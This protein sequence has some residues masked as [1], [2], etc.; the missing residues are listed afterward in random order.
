MLKAIL[1][2]V[3][4]LGKSMDLYDKVPCHERVK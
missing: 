4:S 3:F 1:N 2:F